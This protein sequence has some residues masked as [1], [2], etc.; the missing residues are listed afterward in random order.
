MDQWELNWTGK[1]SF[2]VN[3]LK[4]G[5]LQKESILVFA[6]SCVNN[7]AIEIKVLKSFLAGK[8]ELQIF[9]VPYPYVTRLQFVIVGYNDEIYLFKI[10][11]TFKGYAYTDQF[12]NTR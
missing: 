5:F 6:D 12:I 4:K 2:K 3:H 7:V 9:Y 10:N 1:K 11:P 8:I